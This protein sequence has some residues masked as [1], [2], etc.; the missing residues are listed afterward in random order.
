MIREML[1]HAANVEQAVALMGSYNIIFGGPPLHYLLADSSGRSAL[2]EF[3]QGEMVVTYNDQPW[4]MAT[5]FLCAENGECTEGRCRR[6]DAIS[7]RLAET[8]GRL[9]MEEAMDLLAEVSQ[10][11]TQ[12]SILYDLSDGEIN[13]ALGRDYQQVHGFHLER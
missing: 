4:Q 13:V 5:N 11:S 3:Y 8:Q 10:E 9:A 6:Y 12:W 2:V 1:D 7:E